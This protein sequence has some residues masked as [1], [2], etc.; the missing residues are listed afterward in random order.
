[1]N[2]LHSTRLSSGAV[3]D[4][5]N[6]RGSSARVGNEALLASGGDGL[7]NLRKITNKIHQLRG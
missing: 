6:V 1:M 7:L 2:E 4:A 5:Q 3:H